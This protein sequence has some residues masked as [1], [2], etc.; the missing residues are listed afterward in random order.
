MP[1]EGNHESE[2][3]LEEG[4]GHRGGS[5]AHAH[6]Q[7]IP[8]QVAS[9]LKPLFEQ[10]R[11]PV[12][13]CIFTQKAKNE[14]FNHAAREI[15]LA[16]QGLSDRI[17][18]KE[19]SLSNSEAHKWRVERSPTILFDPEHY[20]IRFVGAPAGGEDPLGDALAAGNEEQ[21]GEQGVQED[22]GQ[23]RFSQT[24]EGLRQPELTLLLPAGRQCNQGGD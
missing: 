1:I 14:K 15:L 10:L 12:H 21:W 17:V 23:D 9:Q 2:R 11:Y 18:F 5:G 4:Q 7:V 16:F 24:C 20:H 8:D 3:P 6:D 19:Y 13:I 22:P